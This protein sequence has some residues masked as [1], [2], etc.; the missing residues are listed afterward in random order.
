MSTPDT[1][2]AT[3]QDAAQSTVPVT[4]QDTA[5]DAVQ[6]MPQDTAQDAVESTAQEMPQAN[7]S[8]DRTTTKSEKEE[9]GRKKEWSQ[10]ELL[11]LSRKFNLDLA[12]KVRLDLQVLNVSM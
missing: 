7:Q 8:Q 4:P 12:P 2:P 3:P 5:Q 1:P 10:E 11:N 6:D 9:N